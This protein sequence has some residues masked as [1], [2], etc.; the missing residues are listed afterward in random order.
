MENILPLLFMFFIGIL[1]SFIN[2]MAGGGSILTLGTMMLI[3]LDAPVAN[4]TNRIGLLIEGVSGA[5]AYKSE[6]FGN[7][8]ESL[9]FGLWAL[10]GALFG[11]I[12]AINI[13]NSA[14]QRI[15]AVV[16]I[17]VVMTLILPQ[18][19]SSTR[20]DNSGKK[21]GG[22]YPT[23]FLIGLYGG[24]IQAGVGFLI[25]A[26]LRHLLHLDLVTINKHKVYIVLLYTIPT[27]FIFGFT[28]NIHWSYAVCLAAGNA[29]GAWLSVK[30]SV[31]KGENAVKFGLSIAILF[32]AIKFFFTF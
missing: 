14:F 12:F 29:A 9:I 32:M 22:I 3:G 6:N 23:M 19:G 21:K 7:L 10:P 11:A 30:I 2:I 25:M 27:L 17:F 8:K 26:S 18:K 5:L 20:K 24:F 1:A 28:Q 13:S 4:G 15:L 16:M 31:K